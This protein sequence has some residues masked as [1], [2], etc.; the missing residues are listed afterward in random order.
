MTNREL[1]VKCSVLFL[2]SCLSLLAQTN[3][4]TQH[5]DIGRTGQNLTETI[6]TPANVSSGNFGK[7]YSIPLDGQAYAQPLYVSSLT[8]GGVNY[9]VLFVATEN[10]SVY[11][12]D[13]NAGGSQ[14]WH[15]NLIDAAHG[16]TLGATPDP[17]STTGC[18]LAENGQNGIVGTPVID[19]VTNTVYAVARSFE[20]G[21][22]VNRLHA[23]DITTGNEKFNGPITI[24]ASTSGTGSGSIN[25]A[26]TMDPKWTN[27]RPGLLLA[28]SGA[29]ATVY[30]GFGSFC[31]AGPYHGWLLGYRAKA[32]SGRAAPAL[33]PTRT[34]PM[35]LT[36]SL[37][38]RAMAH[39]TP[40]ATSAKASCV[41]ALIAVA[42]SACSI[43]LH[44]TTKRIGPARILIW[45]P[46][47]RWFCLILPTLPT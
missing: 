29:T 30:I 11:A 39:M 4:L 27:Q 22:P 46:L 32:H 17:N 12:F 47:A 18:G 20:N 25:G 3:V 21:Y 44:S 19:P 45:V 24:T 40:A 8:I 1:I 7:L 10:D 16:A 6:L 38:L 42:F 2:G 5:N 15:A 31:D 28:G 13:T 9:S 33:P 35:A 34:A 14:L 41:S 37:F 43:R 36:V 26:L 23:I